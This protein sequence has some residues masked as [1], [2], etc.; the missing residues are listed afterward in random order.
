MVHICGPNKMISYPLCP[1]RYTGELGDSFP[2][3]S[4]AVLHA[5]R[6]LEVVSPCVVHRN[7]TWCGTHEGCQWCGSSVGC[8]S[9]SFECDSADDDAADEREHDS[10][11]EGLDFFDDGAFNLAGKS[12]YM[13]MVDRFAADAPHD[14]NACEG[15]RWCGG[16]LGAATRHLDYIAGEPR[17]SLT[18]HTALTMR[19]VD[20]GPH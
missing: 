9:D 6:M 15:T 18:Y 12:I 2:C 13:L 8:V 19:P 16:N 20:L 7:E 4:P 14:A 17:G 1:G 5:Q 11:S 10:E 3:N